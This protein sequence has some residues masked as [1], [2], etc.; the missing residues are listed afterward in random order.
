MI[1]VTR[2][3]ATL[4]LVM[5]SGCLLIA[6]CGA[7]EGEAGQT[8]EEID[9]HAGHNHAPGEHGQPG[10]TAEHSE[11]ELDWCA[12]HSV[13]ESACTRCNPDLIEQFKAAG[14]W[15]AGHE[16]PESH[17][18]LCNPGLEFP[19]EVVF[20]AARIELAEREIEVSLYF[21]PNAEICATD[22][23]MIQFASAKTVER[24]GIRVEAVREAEL[25]AELEAPA[26]VLFDETHATVVT[27]T[28]PALVSRW[29]IAPG[30]VVSTGQALAVLQSPEIAELQARLLSANAAHAVQ[31]RE[32]ARH[33]ELKTRDLVSLADYER[34]VALAAQTSA[35]LAGAR[36][37][38]LS[39]GLSEQDVEVLLEESEVSSSFLLRSPADGFVVERKAQL[40]ELL[41]AGSAFGVLADPSAMW[42]EARLSEE[43][44]RHVAVG[45]TLTFTGDGRGLDQVGAEVIWVSR[46]LD[47]HTRTGVVRAEIREN[48]P[49]LQAGEFGRVQIALPG[50]TDA[51]LVPKD[52]IQWEGCCNVVFVKES[53]DRY[54]PRKVHFT[55][56]QGPYYQVTEGLRAGEEVVVDGAF[57]LKTELK[58]T[59]LGSGCCGLEPTS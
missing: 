32:L 30:D 19:Q 13:P 4:I 42:V 29:L 58:K 1:G 49:H 52:A 45:Q 34:Q 2:N 20:R 11:D 5:I 50:D 31:K 43:Q 46:F 51:V 22:G 56:G 28:V 38:L 16:L 12:E 9:P 39:C 37:L 23:A 36:G 18:R 33:E 15:C 40:G 7:T 17:C 10:A 59:S 25:R 21:R 35:E 26:E 8:T 55:R 41:E 14:D 27:T 48:Q 54:R 6:G 44:L 53:L 47:P 3:I 24:S 57:L